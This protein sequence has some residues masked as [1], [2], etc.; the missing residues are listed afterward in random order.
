[1]NPVIVVIARTAGGKLATR[2][3][4]AIQAVGVEDTVR[5]IKAA[6][7][8]DERAFVE[9]LASVNVTVVEVDMGVFEAY[10]ELAAVNA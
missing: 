4:L 9:A 2:A 10:A 3:A 1:M 8:R 6:F 5:S 7:A